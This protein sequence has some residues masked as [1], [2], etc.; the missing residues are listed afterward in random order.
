MRTVIIVG[1]G[2]V[3]LA[4]FVLAARLAGRSPATGARIFIVPWLLVALYNWYLGTTHG[5][6][7]V[8]ELPFF[9]LVFGV[10]ALAAIALVRRHGSRQPP[11]A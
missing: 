10:P 2:L 3:A 11:L 7:V 6:T 9:A 8:Q 1:V 5:Y 4:V